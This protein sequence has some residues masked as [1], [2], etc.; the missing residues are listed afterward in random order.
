MLKIIV[1]NVLRAPRDFANPSDSIIKLGGWILTVT[2]VDYLGES[3]WN[4][5]TIFVRSAK[6]ML[7][8][9]RF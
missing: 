8:G 6:A 2:L 1:I 7:N 3:V 4:V 9:S 5:F